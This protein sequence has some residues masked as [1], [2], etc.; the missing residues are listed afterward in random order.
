[1]I[2]SSSRQWQQ[3]RQLRLRQ[4]QMRQEQQLLVQRQERQLWKWQP[5]HH[6][7]SKPKP[8]EQQKQ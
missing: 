8:T 2:T 1:M 5:F 6:K 3:E 7:Q 4:E